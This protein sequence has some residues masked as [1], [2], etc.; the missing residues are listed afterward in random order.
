[1]W[2]SL[3]CRAATRTAHAGSL[4]G[5]TAMTC[6]FQGTRCPQ[7]PR[8]SDPVGTGRRT[9]E[10][11]V[12]M[13]FESFTR[14]C[15]GTVTSITFTFSLFLL[16]SLTNFPY[17]ALTMMRPADGSVSRDGLCWHPLPLAP[18]RWTA[19]TPCP[20]ETPTPT[21]SQKRPCLLTHSGFFCLD[22]PSDRFLHQPNLRRRPMAMRA[23]AGLCLAARSQ[24]GV[25]GVTAAL[26]KGPDSACHLSHMSPFCRA[27]T[28]H[29]RERKRGQHPALF[30]R[31]REGKH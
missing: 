12:R 31:E 20:V 5:S 17:Q 2:T 6:P 30:F 15:R 25:P 22:D 1:M 19:G 13:S 24:S 9:L 28:I 26:R 3:R 18:C 27:E 8:P 14:H 29:L 10:A 16:L 23:L 7:K 11:S 4:G 21:L